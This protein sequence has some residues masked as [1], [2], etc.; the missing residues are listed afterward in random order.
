MTSHLVSYLLRYADIPAEDRAVID[1]SFI[2]RYYTANEYISY[3]GEKATGLHFINSGM[4]KI[5]VPKGE[6]EVSVYYFQAQHQF[7]GLLYSYYND[8]PAVQSI[9]VVT[10]SEILSIDM[11]SWGLLE[12]Q[13]TYLEGVIDIIAQ[14]S[15]LEMMSVKNAYLHLNATEKYKRMLELQPE[16]A[17]MATLADIS[18]YLE[19]TP[20]SLSRIRKSLPGRSS[21]M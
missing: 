2:A 10:D 19:M 16:I 5:T 3:A 6:D 17:Q 12:K 8:V 14:R 13:Y 7:T 20:Q 9:Q 18:S 15:M 21:A 4:I 1:S 11:S